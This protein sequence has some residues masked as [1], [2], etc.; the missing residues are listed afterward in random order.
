[1]AGLGQ[2][3]GRRG[4]GRRRDRG[5]PRR[6]PRARR[7]ASRRR[8]PAGLLQRPSV[9]R[10]WRPG[11]HLQLRQERHPVQLLSAG[12]VYQGAGHQHGEVAGHR[13]PARAGQRFQ[14]PDRCRQRPGVRLRGYPGLELNAGPSPRLAARNQTT[15]MVFLLL[16]ITAGGHPRHPCSL[17]RRR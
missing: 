6:V 12:P 3:A 14:P 10:L 4:R 2:A 8:D 5:R 13:Q 11:R 9:L 1:M 16:R 7:P 17:C 15:P